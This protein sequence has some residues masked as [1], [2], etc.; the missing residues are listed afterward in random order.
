MKKKAAI[1]DSRWRNCAQRDQSKLEREHV[2]CDGER[3]TIGMA[4]S[5]RRRN[6]GVD[7]F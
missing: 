5:A 4:E 1:T 6:C 7:S 3:Q 2:F